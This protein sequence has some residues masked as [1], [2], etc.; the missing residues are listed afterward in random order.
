MS[1]R[2]LVTGANGQLGKTIKELYQVNNDNIEFVFVT[3]TELDITNKKDLKQYF[4]TNFFDYCINCAAYTNV[5]QAEKTP[6]IAFKVN[7]EGGKYLAEACKGKNV[8]LIHISTDY[9]FDGEKNGSYTIYDTPNPINE[10]GKSKLLGEEYIQKKLEKY[11][12]IRTSWLYSKKY[13]NNFYRTIL[14]KAKSEKE[15]FVTDEQ[16]GSPTKTESLADYIEG[17]IKNGSKSYGVKHFSDGTSMTWYSFAE[18]ILRENYLYEKVK[19]V[20]ARNYCTFAR[21]P[22]NSV[23]KDLDTN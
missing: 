20:R 5:D 23:I 12:I 11:F 6:E 8:I 18:Q 3:K 4:K 2:V 13:G 14:E 7:A 16:L 21:R 19:L 22:K 1:K 15:I 9:V 10:Y 17:L